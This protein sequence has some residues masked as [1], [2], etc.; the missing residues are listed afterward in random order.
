MVSQAPDLP[1]PSA[2][3]RFAP[4][5]RSDLA[6][7]VGIGR[8]LA[9]ARSMDVSMGGI[10]ITRD[11]PILL[12]DTTLYLD[13][14]LQIPGEKKPI[15]AVARTVW[16]WGPYQAL[17]FVKMAQSD[18]LRLAEYIDRVTPKRAKAG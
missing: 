17:R 14:V 13:V 5:A 15:L 6:V 8:M 10:L 9:D 4:R 12:A 18:R 1:M 3:R 7:R 16:W 2:E 11:R